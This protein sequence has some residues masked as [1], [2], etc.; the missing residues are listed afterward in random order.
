MMKFTP[1]VV[2]F[3]LCL[4]LLMGCGGGTQFSEEPP[5]STPDISNTQD[6]TNTEDEVSESGS[7]GEPAID[8][9]SFYVEFIE[10]EIVQPLC[11][12]C[13]FEQG[14]ASVSELIF[15]VGDD[16]SQSNESRLLAYLASQ[17]AGEELVLSKAAGGSF[18][19]G[20]P[21]LSRNSQAFENLS[22]YLASLSDSSESE[23]DNS[24]SDS[25]DD[26][27]NSNG[28]S[29]DDENN[30]N[31]DDESADA[32]SFYQRYIEDQVTQTACVNCHVED[33]LY[34]GTNL[35]FVAGS[36]ADEQNYN[37]FL[38]FFETFANG[39]DTLL[40]KVLGELGH[41]G[42]NVYASEDTEYLNLATFVQMATA[43]SEEEGVGFFESI[44]FTSDIETLRR[45]SL[46]FAGR[47]PTEEEEV[48]AQRSEAGLRLTIE[49]LMEGEAFHDFLI[50][51]ANDRLLTD[52]FIN[53]GSL[54]IGDPNQA[55]FPRLA[56]RQYNMV[57]SG[58]TEGFWEWY[59]GFL[60]GMS[61][62]P[63]ELIAY[64]VENDLDYRQVL[65]SNYT[66]VNPQTNEVLNGGQSFSSSDVNQFRLA[67]PNGQILV[68]DN[69]D[70][71]YF[72]DVG[73]QIL[74]HGDYVDYPKS[75][76]LNEPAFLNRYPS[77]ETNRNRAR[78]RWT[79]YHFLGVDIEKSA[80]RTTDPEALADTN[81]PTLN[82]PN[83]T[84]CHEVLDPVAGAFQNY[85]D[86]GWYRSS[87][88]GL[89]S[90]PNSYKYPDSGDS[91]YQDNDTWYRDMR[92]PGLGQD[93]APS[94]QNSLRWLAGE[95][96]QDSRFSEAVV[97]FWWPAIMSEA[98]VESPENIND[99]SYAGQLAAYT[100][101]SAFITE[102]AE[103]FSQGFNGG[104]PFVLKD[105]LVELVMSDWFRAQALSTTV[106]AERELA[107]S[108]I[109]VG[110]LLTPEELESKTENLLGIKWGEDTSDWLADGEYSNFDDAYRV[111]YGGIDSVGITERARVL[112]SI[113]SNVAQAHALSVSCPSVIFDLNRSAS[114]RIIF[115]FV[116]KYTTPVS[117]ARQAF[118]VT[119]TRTA[120][121]SS[122]ALGTTL[123]QGSLRIR[124][125]FDSPYYDDVLDSSLL[126]VIHE[127]NVRDS[128]GALIANFEGAN[129]DTLDGLDHSLNSEGE[130][131][132][133]QYFDAAEG[134]VTGWFLWNGYVD[135]P[136]TVSVQ[137][138]Y[139]IE[140]V[141]SP[142]N[143]PAQDAEFSI[144]KNETDQ[145]SDP[146][147]EVQ[148]KRELQ[149]LHQRL[150]GENLDLDSVE[151]LSS[152][153]LLMDIW[154]AR[155]DAGLNP[156]AFDQGAGERCE[157][158]IDDWWL[159]DWSEEFSD[160]QYMQGTW[161]SMLIYFMT[162]YRYLHE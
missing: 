29:D 66:M 10:P 149:G 136:L 112:N 70:A 14:R 90:L 11:V 40:S 151:L 54:D 60:F 38:Q 75:G 110:R 106:S 102:M 24:G 37:A 15:L 97:K 83:C 69:L 141:A 124:V 46:I 160:P 92:S 113:M 13:H 89:D 91:L 130:R 95:I 146:S 120:T 19:G 104:A 73:L 33:G 121:A 131:T 96:V 88:G 4:L 65:T 6:S 82:N 20:G 129:F 21:V 140:V 45:A 62:A 56:T 32:L 103:N 22:L 47:I 81:N 9:A 49:G 117:Q 39:G 27:N 57:S 48:V 34:G 100:A 25:V 152:Y 79:F 138:L 128:G 68:D 161:I 17:E 119:G 107:L 122:H 143:I 135:V 162:D 157:I 159:Q 147:G 99:A 67:T 72:Q 132:G 115:K 111:Y 116:D 30:S 59:R 26:N 93:A 61:R 63:L 84:V 85:G 98:L 148:I 133:A 3:L 87:Y 43:G 36:D 76:V 137:G 23:E 145:Y 126:L 154:Q 50:R 44:T 16:E 28:E 153:Q 5:E 86:E 139:D 31:S 52:A 42:G 12:S 144:T 156:V 35:I 94:S 114:D 127:I 8:S 101:Q 150:L 64:I 71:N 80:T 118:T 74:S 109:G 142:Q 108:G 78:A 2:Y 18:H 53:D 55:Y 125:S 105:L 123:N 7:S 1:S 51:G 158:P 58:N 134:E 155:I 77:T 41:Q